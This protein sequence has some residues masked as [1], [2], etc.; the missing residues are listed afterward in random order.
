MW[1]VLL[2]PGVNP[3]AAKYISY[4]I[5]RNDPMVDTTDDIHKMGTAIRD[6]STVR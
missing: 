6:V 5:Y 3:I 1:A 2:P 4:H